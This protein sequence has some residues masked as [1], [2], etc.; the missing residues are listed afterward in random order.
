MSDP[1]SAISRLLRSALAA[2]ESGH[3]D[4]AEQT[5]RHILEMRCDH[6][7]AQH[8]LATLL[9]GKNEL[10]E[11][12][13]L[14]GTCLPAHSGNPAVQCN[15]AIAL[16]AAERREEAIGILRST[17]ETFGDFPTALY[18]LAK[19]EHDLGNMGRTVDLL[20]RLMQMHRAT[21]DTLILFATSLAAIGQTEAGRLALRQAADQ[22][23]L[24]VNKLNEVGRCMQQLCF[25]EDALT[26]HQKA[27]TIKPD[28]VPD[29]IDSAAA[30]QSLNRCEEALKSLHK[31]LKLAPDAAEVKGQL[32]DLYAGMGDA[33]AAVE[34]LEQ[35]VQ[36]DPGHPGY[37]ERLLFLCLSLDRYDGPDHFLETQKYAERHRGL[38]TAPPFANTP[39]PERRL[40][41]GFLSPH[42]KNHPAH[43]FIY[44]LV[45]NLNRS[46][47]EVFLYSANQREDDRT[48]R[49]QAVADAWR[50]ISHDA[51][52][53][54]AQKIRNDR[55]DILVDLAG[56]TA[57]QPM[58]VFKLKPAPIQA[59]AA[60][61][62]TGLPQMDYYLGAEGFLPE[63][64]APESLYTEKLI[65]LPMIAPFAPQ[66]DDNIAVSDLPMLTQGHLTFGCNARLGKI[67][68]PLLRAW[69]EILD[70]TPKA[71]LILKSGGLE[72]SYVRTFWQQRAAEAG[73]DT[74]R[75][76]L[77]GRLPRHEHLNHYNKIDVGL[78]TYP[79]N[80]F[81]TTCEFLWQGVPVITRSGNLQQARIG[82]LVLKSL[83]LDMLAAETHA[84][85]VQKAVMLAKDP[86]GLASLR[87]SLRAR[88][89]KSVMMEGR[90]ICQAYEAAFRAMW[91]HWCQG[92]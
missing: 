75:L 7:D 19:L 18:H 37:H 65:N 71:R 62:S 80:G 39:Y 50:N 46:E 61:A 85:Y 43:L 28:H 12:L 87:S 34:L 14:F 25:Y 52:P 56:Y 70:Q 35:L 53:A 36:A 59:T 69:A 5:Y 63:H 20:G 77:I 72:D 54:M 9:T 3:L 68:P 11:A 10:K 15:Y 58:A 16:I 91:Q 78:D 74:D 30:L 86:V 57:D 4:Q 32:A 42:Y 8:L 21:C 81:A 23:G 76:H 29:L 27:L 24:D 89:K 60:V 55:I 17:L 1:D 38:Q 6:A 26:T 83:N 88:F 92:R 49:F 73:I 64:L 51:I 33:A 66:E 67:T 31:A 44:P 22:A 48:R 45:K 41:V 84:G 13:D 47:I 79:Y 90:A 82:G 40:R 2:H